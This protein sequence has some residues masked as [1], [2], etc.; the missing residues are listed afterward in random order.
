MTTINRP[1]LLFALLLTALGAISATAQPQALGVEGQALIGEPKGRP[2]SGEELE[3]VTNEVSSLMR[4]PVCQ[5]LSVA[6]SPTPSAVAMK[7]E[8]RQ[9]LAA[10]YTE[11]QILTYFEQSYG[12]FI[13]LEPKAKGFNLLVWILPIAGLLAGLALVMRRVKQPAATEAQDDAPT[14]VDPDLE[15]YLEQVRREVS[16]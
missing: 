12:E 15:V 8:V 2:L 10:G 9:F 11:T 7:E 4:C 3:R 13:R 16:S 1:L 5:G 6:D 14:T